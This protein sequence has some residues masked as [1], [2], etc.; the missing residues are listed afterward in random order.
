M[1][2][3][4]IEFAQLLICVLAAVVVRLERLVDSERIDREATVV[5]VS[6]ADRV[7]ANIVYHHIA[8]H[9]ATEQLVGV[10]PDNHVRQHATLQLNGATVCQGRLP[11]AQIVHVD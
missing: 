5:L 8:A 4:I 1:R 3:T 11:A 9:R 7:I 2:A 6:R 10:L